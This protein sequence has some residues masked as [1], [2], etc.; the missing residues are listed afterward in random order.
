MTEVA[1]LQQSF[2][3]LATVL[4]P[5]LR[6]QLAIPNYPKGF[7]LMSGTTRLDGYSQMDGWK[8]LPDNVTATSK[9]N[10]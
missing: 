6:V 9:G 2:E 1:S 5:R 3:N 10:L 8:N 7:P 4:S